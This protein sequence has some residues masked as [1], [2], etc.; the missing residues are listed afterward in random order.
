MVNEDL[1]SNGRATAAEN[2]DANDADDNCNVIVLMRNCISDV[3]PRRLSSIFLKWKEGIRSGG[4]VEVERV[5]GQD[6]N[7]VYTTRATVAT[8]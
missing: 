6:R 4:E 2:D 1:I 3:R 7:F 5:K 8:N